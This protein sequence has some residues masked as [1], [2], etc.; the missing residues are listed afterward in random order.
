MFKASVCN[1]K[2]KNTS[3]DCLGTIFSII[4][5][6]FFCN[7]MRIVLVPVSLI[8]YLSHQHKTDGL[9]TQEIASSN[10]QAIV[11]FWVFLF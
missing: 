3:R 9:E 2:K 1:L 11:N 8:N 7:L 5:F 10:L 4:G 6:S